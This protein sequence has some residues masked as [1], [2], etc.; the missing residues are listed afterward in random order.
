MIKYALEDMSNMRIK[1]IRTGGTIESVPSENGLQ[2]SRADF[3]FIKTDHEIT[4]A[5]PFTVDSSDL[6]G[7]NVLNIA[8]IIKNDTSDAFVITH[9]TDTMCYTAAGLSFLLGNIGKPIIFTG[10]MYPLCDNN[11][12][13]YDNL[14]FAVDSA[15]S[16]KNSGVYIAMQGGLIHGAKAVK[17][18]THSVKAFASADGKDTPFPNA[19]SVGDNFNHNIKIEYI[20]PFTTEISAD[21]GDAVLLCGYGAGNL[22]SRLK[23]PDNT[24]CYLLSQCQV[25]AVNSSLYSTG[26]N[27]VNKGIIPLNMALPSA[28]MKLAIAYTYEKEIAKQ[29]MQTEYCGEF[30]C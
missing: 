9:G 6:N 10:S 16:I 15:Q 24:H 8:N 26:V 11:S 18:H 21:N 1:I 13:G 28:V 5:F 20:T 14:Q 2:P 25:G 29:I 22:P 3:S 7:E 19:T 27:A 17:M 23:I 4:Y 30:L 12:D